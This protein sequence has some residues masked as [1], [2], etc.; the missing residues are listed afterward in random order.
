MGSFVM[1]HDQTICLVRALLESMFVTRYGQTLWFEIQY[2]K[3]KVQLSTYCPD[4]FMKAEI[5][6]PG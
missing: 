6:G 3:W 1:S 2:R 5:A 4:H